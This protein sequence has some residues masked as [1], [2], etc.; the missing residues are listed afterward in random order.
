MTTVAGIDYETSGL[1][2]TEDRIIEVACCLYEWETGVPLQIL[3][4]LVRPDRPIPPEITKLTG[5]TDEQVD[6]YGRPEKPV[7][8]ELNTMIDSADYVLAHN[9]NSF[10]HPFYLAT[11]HRL[12]LEPSSVF[13]LDSLTDVRW[14]ETIKTRNLG[15]LAAD[16][17]FASPFR[18]RAL[19]DVMTML[20]LASLYSLDDIIAR[21]QEPT[22]HVQ[23]LVSFDE[24]EKVKERGYH[25]YA[26]T[27]TWWRDFKSSDFAAEKDTCG[28][29]TQ[30]LDKAPE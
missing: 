16:H 9:G 25:W 4:T 20:K 12:G 24:K 8:L 27:K 5:I 29:R 26:P 3:S 22:L 11:C 15:H 1:L 19:F 18:H 13:W 21:A 10:D 28:F 30:L 7:F 23:A 17:G 6:V 2:A 14:P